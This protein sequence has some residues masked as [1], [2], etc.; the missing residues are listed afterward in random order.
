IGIEVDDVRPLGDVTGPLVVGRVV[1]IEELAGFKKPIRYCRVEVGDENGESESEE[2]AA[3]GIKTR[4]IVCGATNFVEGDL[5]VVAL[6]GSVLPGGFEIAAGKTYGKL[7]DGMICSARELGLGDEHAGIL[8]L[9][10][11]TASPGDDARVV[12]GLDDA[13]LELAPTPDRGY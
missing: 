12:L 1:E 7:S 6:P 9:P 8:V 5:V 3:R 11:A 2:D 13:V 10:P 4:G